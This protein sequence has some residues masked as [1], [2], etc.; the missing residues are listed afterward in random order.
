MKI[1]LTAEEFLR[2]AETLFRTHGITEVEL[3]DKEP[4]HLRGFNRW[5]FNLEG[6]IPFDPVQELPEPIVRRLPRGL[7]RRT[8]ATREEAEA[9]LSRACVSYGRELVGL[10]PLES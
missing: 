10:L 4:W 6:M 8:Y 7:T 1:R 9:A 2:D 3:T 5:A